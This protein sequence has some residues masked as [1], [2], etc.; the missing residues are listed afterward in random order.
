MRLQLFRTLTIVFASALWVLAGCGGG[1]AAGNP[2]VAAFSVRPGAN[3]IHTNCT[4]C[5]SISPSGAPANQFSLTPAGSVAGTVTWSVSGGDAVSGAGTIIATGLYT[6]PTY[7]TADKVQV[8]FTA[9]ASPGTTA[10]AVITLTPGFLQP[11]TP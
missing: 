1:S 6:P 5:N 9:T 8:M 11:L 10:T 7:L 2:K 3:S 4:G